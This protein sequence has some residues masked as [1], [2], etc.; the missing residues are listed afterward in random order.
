MCQTEEIHESFYDLFNQRFNVIYDPRT[1]QYH[2]YTNLAIGAHSKPCEVNPAFRCIVV[3]REQDIS[4]TPSPFLNRFEKYRVS[5]DLIY[6][7]VL[8]E[9]PKCVSLLMQTVHTKV[10]SSL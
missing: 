2:L 3:L 9:Q 5:H 1:K 4:S 8:L 10:I 7:E 6:R